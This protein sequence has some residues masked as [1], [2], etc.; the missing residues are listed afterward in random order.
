MQSSTLC[1]LQRFLRNTYK[2][3]R[4]SFWETTGIPVH[5]QQSLRTIWLK[6]PILLALADLGGSKGAMAPLALSKLV[7]K[8]GRCAQLQVMW[9]PTNFWICWCTMHTYFLRT[10]PD[11]NFVHWILK[12][13][14]YCY[15]VRSN[16]RK[17]HSSVTPSAARQLKCR[18]CPY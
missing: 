17:V 14:Y 7:K 6:H 10:K 5:L 15:F 18:L 1:H 4:Y 12:V 16:T 2:C 9:H 13:I 8:N 11:F 3:Q